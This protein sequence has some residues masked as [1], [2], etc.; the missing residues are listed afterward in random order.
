MRV[1]AGFDG[2]FADKFIYDH[3]DYGLL[4]QIAL[5]GCVL[6]ISDVSLTRE[7]VGNSRCYALHKH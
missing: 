1:F 6:E 2:N 4:I 3:S 5:N 7:L